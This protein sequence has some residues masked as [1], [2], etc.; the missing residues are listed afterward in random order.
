MPMLI[1]MPNH[2]PT[3][4]HAYRAERSGGGAAVRRNVAA[5][6]Q[7]LNLAV[8]QVDGVNVLEPEGVAVVRTAQG[9]RRLR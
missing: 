1:R 9:G 3:H 4:Q 7:R 5:H 8:Q 6:A 2:T